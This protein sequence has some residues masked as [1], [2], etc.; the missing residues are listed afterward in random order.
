MTYLT[1]TNPVVSVSGTVPILSTGGITPIISIQDGTVDQKGAVQLEDSYTSTSTTTAATPSSIKAV[2]D[3]ATTLSGQGVNGTIFIYDLTPDAGNISITSAEEGQRVDSALASVDVTQITCDVFAYSGHT[4]IRPISDVNGYPIVWA[5]S[6]NR[7]PVAYLGAV[8]VPIS[9]TLFAFHEDGASHT[10]GITTDAKPV[11]SSV[12]FVNGYPGSQ[13]E[14]K[15]GDTFDINVVADLAFDNIQVDAQMAFTS[16]WT[17]GV[18]SGTDRTSTFTIGNRGN[19]THT[20]PARVRVQ[21]STGTWSDWAWTNGT[22]IMDSGIDGSQVVAL[23]NLFPSVENMSQSSIT[24]PAGQEAIKGTESVTIHSTC[25]NFDTIAYSSPTGELTIPNTGDYLEDKASVTRNSGGYNVT[26]INYRIVCVR[27]ANDA[28][29]TRSLVVYIANNACTITMSEPSTYLRSGG[30]DGSSIQNHIIILTSNQRLISTPTVSNPPVDAGTWVG[31]FSGG[32]EIWT[33]TLQVHD[34]DVKAAYS[35]GTLSATNLANIETTTYTGDSS[36]ILRGFITRDIILDAFA[37]EAVMHVESITY[38]NVSMTWSAKALP[39][40]RA[41]GTD[42]PPVDANSWCLDYYDFPTESTIIRI[43]DI[44]ATDAQS[45]A[46]TV[47]IQE[48]I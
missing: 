47:T 23:N 10:V 27:T 48:S 20:Y 28:S 39:N 44:P 45:Q 37:N 34:D 1:S 33:R 36:Y 13:T 24:Y 43:L 38:A 18:A 31:V 40:K 26:S 17:N 6:T 14:L 29:V 42:V 19:T 12:S 2:Y 7:N 30:N 46:T 4:N 9:D 16:V 41:L 3:Y 25:S 8:T 21:K 35:Y 32:P 15:A 5:T 22:G 11:M